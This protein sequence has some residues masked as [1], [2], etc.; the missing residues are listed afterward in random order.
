ML[1]AKEDKGRPSLGTK[2][3]GDCL[4]LLFHDFTAAIGDAN[5][6]YSH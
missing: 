4:L 5:S 3:L 1:Y 6:S 2:G